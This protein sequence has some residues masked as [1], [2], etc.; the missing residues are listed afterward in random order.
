VAEVLIFQLY[1]GLT[2]L[3]SSESNGLEIER[4]NAE[5]SSLLAVLIDKSHS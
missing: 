1:C 3:I 4:D 2:T 5:F